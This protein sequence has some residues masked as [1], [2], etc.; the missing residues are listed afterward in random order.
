MN[1][2]KGTKPYII[3]K[4]MGR[5]LVGYEDELPK[6]N[7]DGLDVIEPTDEQKYSVRYARLDADAVAVDGGRNRRDAG[8][9][10]E[11]AF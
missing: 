9:V 3:N 6:K 1:A 11:I 5:P 2:S 8:V 7:A 10:S 4:D